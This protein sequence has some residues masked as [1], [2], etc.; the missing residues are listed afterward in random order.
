MSENCMDLLTDDCSNCHVAGISREQ[1]FANVADLLLFAK[2]LF[3]ILYC[4]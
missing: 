1:M 2:I 3:A 4:L